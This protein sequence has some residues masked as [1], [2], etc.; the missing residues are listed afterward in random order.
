MVSNAVMAQT[1]SYIEML[2]EG[3]SW[4]YEEGYYDKN[5]EEPNYSTMTHRITVMGDTLIKEKSCKKLYDNDGT[6]QTL[7]GLAYEEERRVYMFLLTN[8]NIQQLMEDHLFHEWTLVYDFNHD[9]GDVTAMWGLG[10][11]RRGQFFL[12]SIDT[13]STG[14]RS[15]CRY[16][17]QSPLMASIKTCVVEGVGG[18]TGLLPILNIIEDGSRTTFVGCY[19]GDECIFSAKDF[20]APIAQ[21]TGIATVANRRTPSSPVHDLQGRR[22]KSPT[23]H[24]LYIRDGRK[25]VVR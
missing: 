24:G 2:A 13:V 16:I 14:Q 7:I 1:A 17:W 6:S 10:V 21:P 25:M 15:F 4:L 3:R 8:G 18:E 12:N 9:V 23:R 22:L 20:D 11:Y 19:D 5:S